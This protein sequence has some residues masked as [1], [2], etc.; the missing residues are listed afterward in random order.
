MA[1]HRISPFIFYDMRYMTGSE[2]EFVEFW[3][4][5]WVDK[6]SKQTKKKPEFLQ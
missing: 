5:T 3:S 2:G 1:T 6:L 4:D